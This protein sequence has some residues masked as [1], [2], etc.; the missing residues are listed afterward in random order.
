LIGASVTERF[1]DGD[2]RVWERLSMLERARFWA[3]HHASQA[4]SHEALGNRELAA[5]HRA[6]AEEFK[7]IADE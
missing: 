2:H 4:A 3:E 5:N 7:L 1:E 6:R